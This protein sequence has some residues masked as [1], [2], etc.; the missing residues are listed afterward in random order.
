MANNSRGEILKILIYKIKKQVTYRAGGM[1]QVWR[2]NS[3]GGSTT[4]GLTW[5][6]LLRKLIVIEIYSLL[7]R[8]SLLKSMKQ[9]Y[10]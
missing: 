5:E 7:G 3:R 9:K 8:Q 6:P 1:S 2:N 10:W 4:I